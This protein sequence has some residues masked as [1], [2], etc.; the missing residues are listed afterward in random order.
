MDNILFKI[1]IVILLYNIV[2]AMIIKS[3]CP[4]SL[5]RMDCSKLSKLSLPGL[6][7][8]P[9]MPKSQ[10]HIILYLLFL[11]FTLFCCVVCHFLDCDFSISQGTQNH[12]KTG[13]NGKQSGVNGKNLSMKRIPEAETIFQIIAKRS[14]NFSF[15]ISQ[16]RKPARSAARRPDGFP[17]MNTQGI[18]RYSGGRRPTHDRNSCTR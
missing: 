4:R 2:C 18:S 6:P 8:Q 17:V 12:N 14:R 7:D 15:L 16:F 11:D 5:R 3:R 10:S 1:F 9:K 13:A